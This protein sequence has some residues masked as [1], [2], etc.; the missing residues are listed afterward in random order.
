LDTVT[1]DGL[2][3]TGWFSK[4]SVLV[5]FWTVLVLLRI[6]GSSIR[7]WFVWFLKGPGFSFLGLGCFLRYW[8]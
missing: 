4:D 8:I 1:N 2:Q 6:G 7:T 3:G 5:S